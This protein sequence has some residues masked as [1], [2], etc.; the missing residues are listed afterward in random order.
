[1]RTGATGNDV[2]R[3]QR[4]L[5][6]AG[7]DLA[8]DGKFGPA[9]EQAVK[10]YQQSRGLAVDGIVGP[11][12]QKALN[13]EA[14]WVRQGDRGDEVEK[15]Q[16]ALRKRGFEI[17]V[18]GVYGPA[19]DKA[20]RAFQ[21][22]QGIQVDGIVGDETRGALR[23][24]NAVADERTKRK[25][26]QVAAAQDA[27]EQAKQEALD[28]KRAA[29]QEEQAKQEALDAKRSARQEEQAKLEALDAK[30][31][32]R[33]EDRAGQETS[34]GGS[35]LGDLASR[36]EDKT[37]AEPVQTES[38]GPDPADVLAAGARRQAA[39]NERREEE[40]PEEL[41]EAEDGVLGA[42]AEKVREEQRKR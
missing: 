6:K 1:M 32:A 37:D 41:R 34:G 11:A 31:A 39:E 30:R 28:A 4:Q 13:N 29:R 3:V 8:V 12:T 15:L 38:K 24:T 2:E 42:L 25:A 7:F 40:L 21:Q 18:D 10:E 9:T 17:E 22:A 14:D 5:K 36:L 35:S 27:T 26:D 20:V 19:T 23:D 16:R 33:Q